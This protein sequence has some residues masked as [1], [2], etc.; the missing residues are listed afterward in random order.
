M[1][2]QATKLKGYDNIF[3]VN[4]RKL[5]ER[6][7]ITQEALAKGAGCS[8]QAISQYMDGS[9]A[10]NID[11]LLKIA[12]YF[13]VSIDYLMGRDKKPNE[14]ERFNDICDYTGLSSGSLLTLHNFKIFLGLNENSEAL[15]VMNSYIESSDFKWLV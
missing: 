5:M 2:K 1:S 10:P 12:D 15:K 7:H 13:D 3:A 11:K 4:L 14:K 9:S 8:R 6:E